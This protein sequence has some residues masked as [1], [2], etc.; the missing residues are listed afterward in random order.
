MRN[1]LQ[2]K[3]EGFLFVSLLWRLSVFSPLTSCPSTPSPSC[4][5]LNRSYT[6][7]ILW[8]SADGMV[9][10]V[11]PLLYEPCPEFITS[12]HKP[13]RGG[14]AVKLNK[15][16][17]VTTSKSVPQKQ[18]Q[19]LVSDMKCTNLPIMDS[20]LIGGLSDPYVLF[21][22]S[23]KELLYSK[24]WPAT[25]IIT[26]NLNPVWDEDMHLTMD[27]KGMRDGCLAEGSM[28]T[29][30]V[31]D[32]DATSGDDVIGSVALNL[33]ELCSELDLSGPSSDKVQETIIS[34]PILRNGQE[35]GMLECKLKTA[36]LAPKEVKSF[37]AGAKNVRTACNISLKSKLVAALKAK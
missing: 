36:F 8:K 17:N 34:R 23:P 10:N 33:N 19:V 6:D 29:L 4:S 27:A 14:F 22:S 25:S 16:Q 9:N 35:Y 11:I 18:I 7:R 26:R 28:L 1:E 5:F 12:D 2:G 15:S 30:T 32:F 20:E 37:L 24:A 3:R 21:V 13:I 31:M